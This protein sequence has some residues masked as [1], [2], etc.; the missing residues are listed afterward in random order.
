MEGSLLEKLRAKSPEEKKKITIWT[1][2]AITLV[3]GAAWAFYFIGTFKENK[4]ETL[5][6]GSA[7]HDLKGELPATAGPGGA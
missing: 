4:N 1:A 3:I 7:T 2:V 5:D 6:A